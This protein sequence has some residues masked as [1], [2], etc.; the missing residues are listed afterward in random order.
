M[1][2]LR[3]AKQTKG[4]AL[5]FH[6]ECRWMVDLF[7]NCIDNEVLRD[8][9]LLISYSDVDDD[10]E[11]VFRCEIGLRESDYSD[12]W[13]RI[14]I[15]AERARRNSVHISATFAVSYPQGYS[16]QNR[17]IYFMDGYE[18]YDGYE[19]TER[20]VE[21]DGKKWFQ[22]AARRLANRFKQFV[23]QRAPYVK[24]IMGARKLNEQYVREFFG[25]IM[26][27]IINAIAER[28]TK[29]NPALTVIPASSGGAYWG[30]QDR[31][32]ARRFVIHYEH[33]IHDT[34]NRYA[35]VTPFTV[36]ITADMQILVSYDYTEQRKEFVTGTLIIILQGV[37]LRVGDTVENIIH[38]PLRVT[39]TK[40]EL[41]SYGELFNAAKQG[42]ISIW[43]DCAQR[44]ADI[45]I[46][47]RK[48]IAE[49]AT[50][51]ERT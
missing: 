43:V 47:R 25:S 2:W 42:L 48:S 20:A 51:G 46:K 23:E 16:R 18:N 12:A 29:Y 32:N 6:T 15:E 50:G 41:G 45:L 31:E 7:E 38:A 26:P 37:E 4:S 10:Y 44:I 13:L 49:S 33:S 35:P 1:K 27:D 22:R 40:R 17:V 3:L 8:Y 19:F 39:V 28:V 24:T 9:G 14:H 11:D 30:Y 21:V 5:D 34:R 36:R